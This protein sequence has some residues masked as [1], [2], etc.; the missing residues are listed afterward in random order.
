MAAQITNV[1]TVTSTAG[2]FPHRHISEVKTAGGEV[3]TRA[4]VAR[5]IENGTQSF[6]TYVAGSQASV[7]VVKCPNCSAA[8]Y[9]KTT[10]DAT[11]ADNLLSLPSF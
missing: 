11:T 3:L 9:I 10:A 8:D 5:R 6:Y 1:N 7:I 4:E 2:V